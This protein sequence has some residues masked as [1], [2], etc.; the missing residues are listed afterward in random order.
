MIR[1]CDSFDLPI[2][3]GDLLV[4]RAGLDR[5]HRQHPQRHIASMIFSEAR[6]ELLEHRTTAAVPST[7]AKLQTALPK[8]IPR[9]AISIGMRLPVLPIP[10]TRAAVGWDRG[11]SHWVTQ[12]QDPTGE[13]VRYRG[14]RDGPARHLDEEDQKTVQW[15]V[16]PTQG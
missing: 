8:S 15:T 12:S 2:Q 5:Q 10:A 14:E 11:S 7:P 1:A 13:P 3:C 9:T 6:Q 16:F 4:D